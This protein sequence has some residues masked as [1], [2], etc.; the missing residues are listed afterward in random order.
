MIQLQSHPEGVVLP[1][2]VQPGARR[3]GVGGEQNGALKV[4]VS[5]VAEKGKAN[6]A[7]IELLCDRL[8]LRK[9]AVALLTGETS[10]EKRLLLRGVT[11]EQIATRLASL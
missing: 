2:R 7:V 4:A 9:S 11:V 5:Q 6:K 3:N 8:E 10:R 1:I